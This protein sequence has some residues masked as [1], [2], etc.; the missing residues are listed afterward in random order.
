MYVYHSKFGAIIRTALFK[1]IPKYGRP[2]RIMGG[3]RG[4]T[5]DE[6]FDGSVENFIVQPRTVF[7]RTS[8]ATSKK[9]VSAGLLLSLQLHSAARTKQKTL[10][11]LGKLDSEL[12]GKTIRVCL[13]KA[14]TFPR[15]VQWPV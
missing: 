2:G 11:K 5:F 3:Q 13:G 8:K 12:Y 7:R 4:F 10:E 6:I 14:E 1:Y 15:S 9:I